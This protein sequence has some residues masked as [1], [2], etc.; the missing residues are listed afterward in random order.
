[1]GYVKGGSKPSLIAGVG[2]GTSYALAGYLLKENKNYGAETALGS[3]IALF[4]AAS[5]RCIKTKWKA[6]VP[7]GLFA[8]G[9][10]A[11]YYFLKKYKEFNYGV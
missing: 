11:T 4:A 7:L 3:S 10:L 6:P 9:G 1:M 8:T 2:L 5:S